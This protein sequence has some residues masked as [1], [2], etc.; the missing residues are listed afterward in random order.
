MSNPDISRDAMEQTT[1]DVV[2]RVELK[3]KSVSIKGKKHDLDETTMELY[4]HDDVIR[5]KK[6]PSV[7][8][9]PLGR[10]VKEG[11]SYRIDPL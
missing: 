2:K 9:I 5:A 6:D 1:T 11:R 3:L 10:L 4:D 8:L 7:A